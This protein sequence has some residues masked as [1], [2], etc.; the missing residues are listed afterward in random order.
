[1]FL[2][3]PESIAAGLIRR[4]EEGEYACHLN[5]RSVCTEMVVHIQRDAGMDMIVTR[6][7]GAPKVPAE[8]HGRRWGTEHPADGRS[9]D[10]PRRE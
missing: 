2:T 8:S 6:L 3:I 4:R 7:A 9:I 10:P 5:A 1:M